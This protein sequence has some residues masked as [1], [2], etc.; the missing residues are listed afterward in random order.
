MRVVEIARVRSISLSDAVAMVLAS[1]RAT[2]NVLDGLAAQLVADQV[3][4]HARRGLAT[5]A[6]HLAQALA[7]TGPPPPAFSSRR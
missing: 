4:E 7:N 2:T 5:A 3:P 6:G 1:P